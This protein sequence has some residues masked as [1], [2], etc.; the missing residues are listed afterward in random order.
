M[1]RYRTGWSACAC[2]I[3]S[4][5]VGC[6][7]WNQINRRFMQRLLNLTTRKR[8]LFAKVRK[9]VVQEIRRNTSWE[10]HGVVPRL[11]FIL[12]SGSKFFVVHLPNCCNWFGFVL[13]KETMVARV[14]S[15]LTVG[16]L[17]FHFLIIKYT[18]CST[19]KFIY[20]FLDKYLLL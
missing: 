17:D 19:N 3:A 9:G 5:F 10:F 1:D 8:D 20:Y 6:W 14:N 16:L 12:L 15:L 13:K 2:E 7:N 11:L 4:F 18:L